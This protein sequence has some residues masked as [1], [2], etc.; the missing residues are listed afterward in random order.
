MPF[1]EITWE[2]AITPSSCGLRPIGASRE[3][4]ADVLAL[5]EDTV[6]HPTGQGIIFWENLEITTCP[7]YGPM[8]TVYGPDNTHK[9]ELLA[10]IVA[11]PMRFWLGELVSDRRYPTWHI[12][13][14]KHLA[15]YGGRGK[16]PLPD[17]PPQPPKA[18][19]PYNTVT[20]PKTRGWLPTDELAALAAADYL[21]A[22]NSKDI[23]DVVAGVLVASNARCWG[24]AA[25]KQRGDPRYYVEVAKRPLPANAYL[26][27]E[28]DEHDWFPYTANGPQQVVG[29]WS[30]AGRPDDDKKKR[31]PRV[32]F[33]FYPIE[34]APK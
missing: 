4:A 30:S 1:R 24:A 12:D 21:R 29:R 28:N 34:G 15:F 22:L 33:V 11:E 26:V 17:I 5:L 23:T 6:N 16:A 8:A 7:R 3:F 10:K 31:R 13:R 2:E 9:P 27:F 20:F 25:Y 18:K 14:A 19:W 32:G